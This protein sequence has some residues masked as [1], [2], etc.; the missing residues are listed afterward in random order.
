[1]KLITHWSFTLKGIKSTCNVS[2]NHYLN[3][4]SPYTSLLHIVL[5]SIQV[6]TYIGYKKKL[7]SQQ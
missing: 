2:H 4:T 5:R 1:M 7:V 6:I 3:H